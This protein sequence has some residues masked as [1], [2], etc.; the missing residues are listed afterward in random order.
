M[1]NLPT[2]N[3]KVIESVYKELRPQVYAIFRSVAMPEADCED[4]VQDVFLKL[5]GIETLRTET[6]KSVTMVIAMRL[7]TDWLRKRAII[8]NAIHTLQTADIY[9]SKYEDTNIHTQELRQLE[10]NAM[11]RLNETTR[12]IYVLSRF[13]QKSYDEIAQIMNMSYR[14]VESRVYRSRQ[15]VRQYIRRAL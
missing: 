6:V 3:K 13:E 11:D 9:D 7:R 14:A 12:R 10:L 15:E 2:A 4:L 5:L 1:L 8:H